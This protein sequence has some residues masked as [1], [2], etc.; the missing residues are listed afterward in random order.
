VTRTLEGP[1]QAEAAAGLTLRPLRGLPVDVAAEVRVTETAGMREIRPAAF[2]VTR[3]P[4]VAL[5]FRLRGEAYLQGGYVAGRF[6]TA[7]VDGQARL[8]RRIAPLGDVSELRAGLAVSGGAQKGAAR[9]DIGP[10]V[11]FDLPLGAARSRVS[12][13]YRWR[14]AGDAE[15]GNGPAVTVSAGF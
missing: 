13:G 5:P 14:V 4:P 15:P 8:D 11:T 12:A 6:A 7:F 1:A 9:L 10:A 2:A 3:L